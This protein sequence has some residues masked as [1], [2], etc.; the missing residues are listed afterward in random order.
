MITSRPRSQLFEGRE[1]APDLGVDAGDVPE[2]GADQPG[3]LR[4]AAGTAGMA[5]HQYSQR[6]S[7]IQL[8]SSSRFGV[9]LLRISAGR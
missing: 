2:V 9:S 8:V 3:P 1:D 5:P 7:S 6:A 4:D